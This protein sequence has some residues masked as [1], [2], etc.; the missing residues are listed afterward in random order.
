MIRMD[1]KKVAITLRRRRRAHKAR[2][3]SPRIRRLFSTPAFCFRTS[4][5]K[6]VI[7]VN[8]CVLVT[9]ERDGYIENNS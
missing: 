5:I 4:V 3:P 8:T 6:I 1:R 2:R 9:A 7:N